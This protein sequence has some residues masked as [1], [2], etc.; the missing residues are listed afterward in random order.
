[1]L[2]VTSIEPIH[3]FEEK[4]ADVAA[5]FENRGKVEVTDLRPDPSDRVW[6]S[7][8]R[9]EKVSQHPPPHGR[10][11]QAAAQRETGNDDGEDKLGNSRSRTA[12]EVSGRGAD[13][14]PAMRR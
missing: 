8:S 10:R 12:A 14:E 2:F 6:V 1:M 13:Y 9:G 7:N 5:S 3:S 4:S 11:N